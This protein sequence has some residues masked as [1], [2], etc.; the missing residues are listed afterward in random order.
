MRYSWFLIYYWPIYSTH[1]PLLDRGW[2][3][4][5]IIPYSFFMLFDNSSLILTRLI[6]HLLVDPYHLS[7]YGDCTSFWNPHL[8]YKHWPLK[9]ENTYQLVQKKIN[10]WILTKFPFLILWFVHF[11]RE[12]LQLFLKQWI[13]IFHFRIENT[14]QRYLLFESIEKAWISGA[15]STNHKAFYSR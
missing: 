8:W 15:M 4:L 14:E 6:F 5:L 11:F 2:F 10:L 1:R 13:L 9:D 3:W 7:Y 12:F